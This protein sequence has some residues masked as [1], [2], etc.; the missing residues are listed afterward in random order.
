MTCAYRDIQ[1]QADVGIVT[2]LAGTSVATETC[3]QVS[4]PKFRKTCCEYMA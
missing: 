1:D 3:G 2:G 4:P